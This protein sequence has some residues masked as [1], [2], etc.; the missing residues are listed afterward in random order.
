VREKQGEITLLTDTVRFVLFSL[1]RDI[2]K[3]DQ[4]MEEIRD[5]MELANE[6]SDV[7]SQPVG[8]GVEMD[9]VSLPPNETILTSQQ[10][11]YSLI[12]LT[13]VY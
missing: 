4:T 10:P 3:V 12:Q 8:F 6:I 13:Y 11:F 2:A 1:F 9:D 7:I 5:Q